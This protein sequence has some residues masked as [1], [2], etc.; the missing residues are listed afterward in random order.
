M[1]DI[2][3]EIVAHKRIEVE[4]MKAETP[5][6]HIEAAATE[7]SDG[8]LPSLRAALTNSRTGIIAEFKRRSPSKGWIKE[9]GRADVI[10]TEYQ[11]NGAAAVSILTDEAYFG[12]ADAYVT[13]ARKA[14]LTLPVLYKNFVI[15]EYQLYEA[16]L[17]G[18]SAVLLIAAVLSRSECSRLIGIAHG[19]GL[20]VLLEMHGED[21]ADYA[22]LEPDVCGVNN[23]NLGTF[24]TDVANSFR[25]AVL[26]PKDACKVSES[27]ISDPHTIISLRQAGYRG[28]LIG[29][30]FMK[31]EHPGEELGRFIHAI[32]S[33]RDK[34]HEMPFIIKVC[35]LTD[36]RNVLDVIN[37]GANTTGFIFYK[38]SP[39][40]V[41]PERMDAI[42]RAIDGISDKDKRPRRVGVFV[43]APTCDIVTAVRRYA[44]DCV[45][46]HGQEDAR[47]LSEIREAVRTECGRDIK[48]I[49]A[50]SVESREDVATY[51]KYDGTADIMLFDTKGR[52]V[53]GNGKRFDWEILKTYDG[54]LP[55]IL[56][57]GISPC[58]AAETARLNIPQ[59][60]GIDLNSRFEVSPGI[61]DAA[62]VARFISEFNG[63]MTINK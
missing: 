32:E 63:Y 39:R 21:E 34:Q 14:G 42:C 37:A 50:I 46:M 49:K 35:G 53:G 61:K 1:K 10:P 30:Q 13:E 2:L 4:R 45:Q 60:A 44:L 15:D 54:R 25:M 28:F 29:E 47:Q 56:S 52:A 33:G 6:R 3:S 41:S 7:M 58:D 17:C 31:S 11:R 22:G 9:D 51:K 23:R 19:L 48:I 55:F 5:M 62:S 24:V 59:L 27:G 43:N 12:G 18:A 57:G 16:R 8:P 36:P 26:L 20:E 40:Y 38:N